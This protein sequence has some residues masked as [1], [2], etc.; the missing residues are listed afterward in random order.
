[1][2][3]VLK[4]VQE[5]T[6]K[7][8]RHSTSGIEKTWDRLRD[9]RICL[10]V[11]GFSGSGKSTFLT[12][13]IH[14]LMHF[15]Q[16]TLPAFS[17]ILQER[18]LGAELHFPENGDRVSFD[19]ASSIKSL[20]S[21]PPQWPLPTSGLSSLVIEIRYKP[22]KRLLSIPGKRLNRLFVEI[23][24][25]PGEWLLDL[26]MLGMSFFDWSH[27][28]AALYSSS[29]RARL[30]GPL[31][32]LMEDV[33]PFEQADEERIREIS[34]HF[35]AFLQR[36][37]ES[38]LSL[39]QP[40]QL[41]LPGDEEY[42][43]NHFFPLMQVPSEEDARIKSAPEDCYYRLFESRYRNYIESRVKPFYQNSFSGIDRQVILVDLLG[44]LNNGQECFEDLR[45]SLSQVLDSFQYGHN[46]LLLRL[47][48][49]RIEKVL[50]AAS[51]ID[52]VLP[53]QHESSR[54]LMSSLIYDAYRKARYKQVDTY[55]EVIAS[56]RSTSTRTYNNT[57]HLVGTDQSG[58]VGLMSHPDIPDH[59]PVDD[60]WAVFNDWHLRKLNPPEGLRLEY[61]EGLP[62]IRLDTVMRELL[63]DKFL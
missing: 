32:Q 55:C 21:S 24:D 57:S 46:S 49:P 51:K 22:K 52:Q 25:Y 61:G 7:L 53:E 45:M 23:R 41:L 20:S 50:F 30:L 56:V 36:C 34:E 4:S 37:R 6:G 33:D 44:A 60:E 26:P 12:S 48:R 2:K 15:P 19:Y 1:M 17:P 54:A 14:Q 38:G 10:G 42:I 59:I 27:A 35:L 29:P 40:G 5:S 28:C 31:K 8:A 58:A 63:G 43:G 9:R 11:T 3:G 16:A 39:I 18:I 13:F 62:H 47:F